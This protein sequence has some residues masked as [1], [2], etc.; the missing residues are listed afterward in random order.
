MGTV[1]E[2]EGERKGGGLIFLEKDDRPL[3]VIVKSI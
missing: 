2:E 1:F 3:D